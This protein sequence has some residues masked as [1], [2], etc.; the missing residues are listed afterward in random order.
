MPT[1]SP[2][3]V[4]C[5]ALFALVALVAFFFREPITYNLR[6]LNA[7]L[8]ADRFYASAPGITKNIGYGRAEREKLDVYQP[9]AAGT[10]PVII[11]VHGGSWT[12]GNKEL[13]SPVAQ[14]ILP[15]NFVVVVP[16]YTIEQQKGRIEDT[17]LVFRQAQEI[18]DVVAW[19][20]EHI[21]LF[22]GDPNRITLGGHSA[23]AHLTGL[24]VLDPSWLAKRNHSPQEI[25][26]WYGVSGPYSLAAQA[27]F[28]R[29]VKHREPTLLF[30]VF[31]GDKNFKRGSPQTFV[32]ADTPPILLIHGDMD[33][34]VP[35]SVAQN[36]HAALQQA[37]ASAELKIYPNTTHSGI[38]FDALAQEKP[39]LVQDII[40]FAKACPP[41]A[42]SE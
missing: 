1:L 40:T 41:I 6:L 25:C 10:F 2:L 29:N 23:G 33:E 20:R 14:A 13:Y 36:L 3:A 11:W 5:L 15:A 9:T 17:P 7:K 42:D 12:S 22:N 8:I 35:V 24:V 39:K 4:L 19:T 37:G 26:G 38:L 30:E 16:N 18:A 32:R 34:T 27:D 31:G 28:E 21:A